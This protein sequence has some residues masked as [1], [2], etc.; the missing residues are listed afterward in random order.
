MP[1]RCSVCSHGQRG[2]IDEALATRPDSIR[3]IAGRFGLSKTAVARHKTEHLPTHLAKAVEA[4]EISSASSLLEQMMDLQRRTLEILNQPD[5][6]RVAVA[7]ISQARQNIELLAELTGK[8]AVQPTINV[9]V[10]PQWISVRAV[11]LEALGPFPEARAAVAGRLL[12]LG[13]GGT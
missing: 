4:Q 5:S 6:Q 11:L 3:D 7:A 9:L 8:L 1:R 10:S 13:N 2:A 12:A